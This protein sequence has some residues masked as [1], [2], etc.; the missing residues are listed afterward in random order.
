MG[1]LAV[2]APS[3]GHL[4]RNCDGFETSHKST[5]GLKVWSFPGQSTYYCIICRTPC[6]TYTS[7]RWR[8][9]I[10]SFIIRLSHISLA[11]RFT[12]HFRSV[13]LKLKHV[14]MHV[15]AWVARK[16]HNT[17]HDFVKSIKNAHSTRQFIIRGFLTITILKR[18][19]GHKKECAT[20]ELRILIE[21]AEILY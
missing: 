17:L 19:S 6:N 7:N 15:I 9:Q 13:N 10:K 3:P 18:V 16:I 20:R 4:S 14:I 1:R 12:L 5:V 8:Y 2:S 11:L 21:S